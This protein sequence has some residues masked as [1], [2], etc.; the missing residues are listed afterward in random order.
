[1][2]KELLANLLSYSVP[3]KP[4]NLTFLHSYTVRFPKWEKNV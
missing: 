3:S 4:Y 2:L 1:M